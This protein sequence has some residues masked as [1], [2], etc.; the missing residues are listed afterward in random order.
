MDVL[1]TLTDIRDI[2]VIVAG[3]IGI[4]ALALSILFTVLIGLA[5]LKLIR[6]TRGTVK[7]GLGPILDTARETTTEVKGSTDFVANTLVRPLIRA[8]GVVAGIRRGLN[9][10]GRARGGKAQDGED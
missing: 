4:V 8:Y 1:S 9:V 2:V 10:L 5:V 3:I 6:A 7:D